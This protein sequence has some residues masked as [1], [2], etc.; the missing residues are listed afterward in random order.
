MKR[1]A[2]DTKK[3]PSDAINLTL[4]ENSQPQHIFESPGPLMYAPVHLTRF[5]PV[6]LPPRLTLSDDDLSLVLINTRVVSIEEVPLPLYEFEMRHAVEG[7]AMGDILLRAQASQ[8]HL[9]Q[10]W[11]VWLK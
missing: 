6:S 11:G 3:D 1:L 5:H 4:N 10:R 8:C 2:V 9:V 7:H